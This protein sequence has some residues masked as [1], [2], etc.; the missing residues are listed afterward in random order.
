[1]RDAACAPPEGELEERFRKLLKST[2]LPKPR[3]QYEVRRNGR[4]LARLDFAYPEHRLAIET[5]GYAWHAGRLDWQSDRE[6]DN[7]LVAM[8][9]QVIRFTWTDVH[10][11]ADRVVAQLRDFFVQ[12][13]EPPLRFLDEEPPAGM[14]LS[15]FH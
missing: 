7:A 8:G 4:F 14:R 9:W 10:D 15:D 12:N 6:R 1:M 13:P 11:R 3:E 5:D 2:D